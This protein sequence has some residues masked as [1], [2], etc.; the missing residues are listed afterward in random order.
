MRRTSYAG[1]CTLAVAFV[2]SFAFQAKAVAV[3]IQI[4][5][6]TQQAMQAEI[7]VVG[8][9]TAI[10]KDVSKATQFPGTKDTVDYRVGVVKIAD[11]IQG[12]KGLTTIRVGW[13][14]V[15]N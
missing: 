13:Q 15:Q 12:A 14:Q 11:N 10:E 6:P 5:T 3:A 7:I 8:K 4:R 1:F 2:F 9:V